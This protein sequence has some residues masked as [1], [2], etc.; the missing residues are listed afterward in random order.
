MHLF[1]SG[2]PTNES[3]VTPEFF[4]YSYLSPYFDEAIS[5]DKIRVR[6]YN[7]E[8]LIQQYP[9]ASF[10]P[11]H[12]IPR[13]ESPTDDVRFSIDFSLVDSINRDI[14]NMF[15][16]FESLENYI[17]S[18]ELVYS[19]DYPDL[20]RLR[21]NYFNR[22]KQK[23]DFKAFFEFYSWFDSTVSTFIE[24]LLPRKTAYKGTNFIVE[25]HMLE[26]AKHEYYSTDIYLGTPNRNNIVDKFST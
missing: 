17:G 8:S 19:P 21:V 3:S 4:R 25:S 13:S 14:A 1:G 15:S 7:D 18:P 10:A 11:V 24:Q 12:E 5:S 9:W 22:L 20:E 6:G 2:F 26:R 16:T 23:L